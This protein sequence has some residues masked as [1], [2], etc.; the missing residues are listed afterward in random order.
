MQNEHGRSL[1]HVCV[2]K[3]RWQGLVVDPNC[4]F[5]IGRLKKL[6]HDKNVLVDL[7]VVVLVFLLG[8]GELT[9]ER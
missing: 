9:I 5:K 1:V 2:P 8:A 3:K 6:L 7:G 4:C